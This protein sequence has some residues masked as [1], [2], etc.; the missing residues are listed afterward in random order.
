MQWLIVYS[1]M[2]T[3]GYVCCSHWL[4]CRDSVLQEHQVPG[5]GPGG[6]DQHPAILAVLLPKHPG[7]G[8]A[9]ANQLAGN[10][11]AL[12]LRGHTL[13]MAVPL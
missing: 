8:A 2:M 1:D 5:L 4:Q 10:G 7:G 12:P 11:C 9:P 6:A 3:Q 13:E